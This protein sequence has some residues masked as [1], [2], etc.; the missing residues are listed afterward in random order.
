MLE[1]NIQDFGGAY[2]VIPDPTYSPNA[3]VTTW[4]HKGGVYRITHVNREGGGYAVSAL[5]QEEGWLEE[6]DYETLELAQAY[7][8]S[9]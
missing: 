5:D 7:V 6:G 4:L 3:P 8:A 2:I 9:K 1:I